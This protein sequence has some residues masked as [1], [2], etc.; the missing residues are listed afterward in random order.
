MTVAKKSRREP[1]VISLNEIG[2]LDVQW[3]YRWPFPN[4]AAA[5]LAVATCGSS[6]NHLNKQRREKCLQ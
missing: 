6:F 2:A 4:W 5:Q 3:I 1:F